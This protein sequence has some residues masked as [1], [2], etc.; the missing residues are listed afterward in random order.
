LSATPTDSGSPPATPR[1][2]LRRLLLP[3]GLATPRGLLLRAAFLAALFSVAHL[4]GL[5]DYTSVFSLSSPTGGPGGTLALALGSTYAVLYLL[6]VLLVP[7]LVLGGLLLLGLLVLSS[8]R[9]RDN[10]ARGRQSSS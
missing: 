10:E 7:I 4:A 5:R 8:R 2:L 9:G 1:S 3:G 6:F